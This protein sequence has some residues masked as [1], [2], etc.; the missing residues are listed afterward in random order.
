MIFYYYGSTADRIVL[1]KG[2]S[3]TLTVPAG[4]YRVRWVGA[5]ESF[6]APVRADQV[7]KLVTTG[8]KLA[9]VES[10][11]ITILAGDREVSAGTLRKFREFAAEPVAPRAPEPAP[12]PRAAPAPA[13]SV[14]IYESRPSPS[15]V[16]VE[17]AYCAPRYSSVYYSDGW[18]TYS[19]SYYSFGSYR[20]GCR[21]GGLFGVIG[22]HTIVGAGLGA[23][24]DRRNRGRGAAVGAV[25][26]HLLDHNGCRW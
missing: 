11:Q 1:S 15:V 9:S 24:I 23:V 26:G 16:Y 2:E 3:R 22:P 19:S 10:V 25:F 20:S 18:P 13:S 12:E 4:L 7:T 8:V 17:P 5:A 21:D 14:Y 6:D